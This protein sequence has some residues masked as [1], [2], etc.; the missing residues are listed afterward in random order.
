MFLTFT[1]MIEKA[2]NA[3][4]PQPKR[5]GLVGMSSCTKSYYDAHLLPTMTTL[6]SHASSHVCQHEHFWLWTLDY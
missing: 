5:L 4:I 3:I 1:I 6:D 2:T